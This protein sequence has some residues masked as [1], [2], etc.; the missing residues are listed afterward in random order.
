M[1][2]RLLS[3]AASTIAA[4]TFCAAHAASL[5]IE[6]EQFDN[7]GGWTADSQFIDEM[8]SAYLL[9]HG[10]GK[11]V[12][13][14]ETAVEIPE[15]GTYHVFARTYNWTSPWHSGKGA[16]AF[17]IAVNG[18]ALPN[19]LGNKGESWEWQY[20]GSFKSRPGQTCEIALRDLSGFDGRCD[21]VYLTSDKDDIPPTD[22]ETLAYWRRGYSDNSEP[23]DA[24]TYDLVVVGGG[25]AGMH[26]AVSAARLGLKVAL[27]QNRPVLGGNNS[28]EVRVHLGGALDLGKYPALGTMLKEYAP[29]IEGNAQPAANYGDAAKL[30]W[31]MAEPNISLFLNTHINNAETSP[32]GAIKSVTGI[33][34]LTGKR[35]RFTAPLFCDATGDGMVG[36]LAG[37]DFLIGRESRLEF[38][39][40]SAPKQADA[41]TMGASVQWRSREADG[42]K[43]SFP[44]FNYGL[45]FS[46]STCHRTPVGEWTWETG[47][48]SDQ[49][50]AFERVRDYGML[51]AYSNWSYLVNDLKLY[52][53]RELNWVAHVGGKRETR[54]L[55]GDYILKEDDLVK[56]VSHEDA[57]FTATW[58]IDLHFPDP[59]NSRHFPDGPFIASNRHVFIHPYGVPYRCLYSRNVKNLFMAGRDISCTHVALGTVRVMRTTA[60]MGEVVGMA[61]SLCARHNALPRDIYQH[62][63]PELKELMAT[64]TA[65]GD[66]PDNQ[67]YNEGHHLTE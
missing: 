1:R 25:I 35:L 59:E 40:P 56:R 30:R 6:A 49:L 22:A 48:H 19:E 50:N 14:A 8:G 23:S 5:L 39:E 41:M 52:T 3:L 28:S 24:G 18:K 31:V 11:P 26:A 57:S 9:A 16:G 42:G 17:K 55:L 65:R 45:V 53:D 32:D 61:A 37:A 58:S 21:A 46:D 38:G 63:L 13:D 20:A 2:Q 10:L 15:A 12:A 43:G 54:R 27:V 36:F 66:L 47:M 4:I 34:T 29:T 7:H 51:V 33:E 64:G 67:R 44:K 60:M 62:H